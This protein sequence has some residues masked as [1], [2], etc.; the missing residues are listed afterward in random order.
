MRRGRDHH[1]IDVEEAVVAGLEEQVVRAVVVLPLAQG[2]HE[3]YDLLPI[4]DD[5]MEVGLLVQL[6]ETLRGQRTEEALRLEVEGEDRREVTGRG[7]S[8]GHGARVMGL[9]S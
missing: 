5:L 8:Q 1:P 6:R 2:E 9:G 3:G 4:L 7:G